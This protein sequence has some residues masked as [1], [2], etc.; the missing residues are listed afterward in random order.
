MLDD[1]GGIT[2]FVAVKE[3]I[4]DLKRSEEERERFFSLSLDLQAIAGFDGYL[5]RVNP[6]FQATLGLTPEE[7]LA[8][9]FLEFIYPDDRAATL[10]SV[11]LLTTGRT[12]MD[13]ESRCLCKDGSYRWIAWTAVPILEDEVF[14]MVGRDTT[15]RRRA[16]QALEERARLAELGAEVGVA[17]TRNI[18]LPVMLSQSAECVVRHLDAAFVR[19]WMVGASGDTLEL[20]ASAG[21]Y[22]HLDG[23]HSRVPFGSLKIGLIAQDA[24]HI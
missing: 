22:T 4:S 5:K 24:G 18:P 15:E 23:P 14:Y 8:R 13:I 1:R 20:Q 12:Q 19:I 11:E 6:A 21:M 9:P 3:D 10:T 16:E 17:L 2:H 7:L